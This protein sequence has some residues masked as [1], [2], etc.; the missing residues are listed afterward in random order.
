MTAITLS[1]ER[2]ALLVKC[3]EDRATPVA[4][5]PRFAVYD[6]DPQRHV[7]SIT[8]D[9]ND[10]IVVH[11]FEP[12]EIDNN[13]GHFVAEELLPL[14]PDAQSGI[15]STASVSTQDVFEHFVGEIV[16][17]MDGS[18][19]RAWHLFYDNTLAALGLTEKARAV[20]DGDNPNRQ[21]F[22]ADFAAIYG[23]AADLAAEV[24]PVTLFDAATCF[25]FFPLL[26]VSGEWANGSEKPRPDRVVACDLNPALVSLARDYATERQLARID[27]LEADILSADIT[28]TVTPEAP[29]FDVVTAIHLLE[30]LEPGQTE[31]A[32][33][34]LWSLT[35]RRLIVAVPIEETPDE[36]FGHRQVFC[37]ESL[38]ALGRRVDANCH[39]FED[40]G[41]FLVIDRAQDSDL[42]REVAA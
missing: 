12:R 19:R 22:I 4:K 30:H 21:D 25:G 1:R 27:F 26:L 37:P 7:G 20:P 34:V 17:S 2:H 41:A 32:M 42:R 10:V 29:S 5:S 9:P 3:L 36:R 11:D 24:S 18:E 8:P 31:Q 23:R 16:R 40:H 13:I 35:R 14:L 15:S 38:I 6:I 33:D 39:G 28:R